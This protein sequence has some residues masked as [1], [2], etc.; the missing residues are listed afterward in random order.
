LIYGYAKKV[1]RLV[2]DDIA[3]ISLRTALQK[4]V[5][6]HFASLN[7][8]AHNDSAAVFNK[9]QYTGGWAARVLPTSLLMGM[10]PARDLCY[11]SM[12]HDHYFTNVNRPVAV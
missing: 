4:V 11:Q 8:S 7:V 3:D 6:R 10:V 1:L 12:I 2:Q 5:R 9:G